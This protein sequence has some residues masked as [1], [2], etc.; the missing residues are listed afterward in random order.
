ML[1]SYNELYTAM[2]QG[3]ISPFNPDLINGASIDVTLGKDIYVESLPLMHERIINLSKKQQPVMRHYTSTGDGYIL[4]PSRFALAQTQQVFNLPHDIALLFSLKSSIARAG[5]D[6]LK[7]GWGDPWWHGSVLTLELKSA[8]QFHDILL[9]EGMK[10]GQVSLFRC[11]PV[12]E[13]HGYKV[14]GRY[15]NSLSVEQ[16]KG[17]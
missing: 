2:E 15:N 13:E 17:V 11:I 8:L 9:K 14:K 3:V 6:H 7:A 5:L 10:I 1:L 16:T 12:P 4:K